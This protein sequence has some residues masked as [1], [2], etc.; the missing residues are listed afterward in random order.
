MGVV[1]WLLLLFQS[2][3]QELDVDSNKIIV[4]LAVSGV[5]IFAIVVIR[6]VRKMRKERA[7]TA[8]EL[9]MDIA[10]EPFMSGG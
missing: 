9:A 3:F 4:I 2:V 6:F 7:D 10:S 5:A 1:A 8:M